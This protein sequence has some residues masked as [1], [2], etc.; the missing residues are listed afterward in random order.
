[1]QI[2]ST[3]TQKKTRFRIQELRMLEVT[4]N[5]ECV[6]EENTGKEERKKG[7]NVT[8]RM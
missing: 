7:W 6:Q 4:E 5:T 2:T 3:G 8:K 1:L